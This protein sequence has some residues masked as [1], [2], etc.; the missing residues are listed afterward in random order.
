MRKLV[1]LAAIISTVLFTGGIADA[2]PRNWSA[3]YRNG[4]AAGTAHYERTSSFSGN[5]V[6]DGTLTVK[7]ADCYYVLLIVSHDL[8]PVAHQSPQQCGPGSIPISLSDSTFSIT[9][10]AALSVCQAGARPVCGQ[11]VDVTVYS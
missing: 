9:W 11:Q 2:A 10:S 7:S 6:V 4:T 5:L 8:M 3:S 1:L